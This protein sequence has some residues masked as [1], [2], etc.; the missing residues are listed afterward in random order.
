MLIF[1]R[2]FCD[3]VDVR[4]D[5]EVFPFQLPRFEVV[6]VFVEIEPWRFTNVLETAVVASGEFFGEFVL[7]VCLLVESSEQLVFLFLHQFLHLKPLS[8]ESSFG[9]RCLSLH[10]SGLLLHFCGLLLH[11]CGLLVHHHLEDLCG[12]WVDAWDESFLELLLRRRTMCTVGFLKVL[13]FVDCRHF[14]S[15]CSCSRFRVFRLS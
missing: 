2:R 4:G 13:F 8:V 6:S 7:L 11:F 9:V 3:G 1:D 15:V 5:E 14:D 10:F 12:R